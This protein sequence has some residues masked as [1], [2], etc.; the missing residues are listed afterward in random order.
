MTTIGRPKVGITVLG[1]TG[2]EPNDGS[3]AEI[4]G[5]AAG[6]ILSTLDPITMDTIAG[7]PG[8][9][10]AIAAYPGPNLAAIA[11]DTATKIIWAGDTGNGNLYKYFP[12]LN[13]WDDQQSYPGT[14]AISVAVNSITNDVWIADSPSGGQGVVYKL[15]GGAGAFVAH[16]TLPVNAS[17]GDLDVNETTGDVW[18]THINASPSTDG[19]L[20]LEGGAQLGTFLPVGSWPGASPAGLE[21]NSA[22]GDVWTSSLTTPTL[23]K[24]TGGTGS[25]VATGTGYAG[26]VMNSV[27][28]DSVNGHIWVTDSGVGTVYKLP[29]GAD[30]PFETIGSLPSGSPTDVSIDPTTY[31]AWVSSTSTVFQYYDAPPFVQPTVSAHNNIGLYLQTGTYPEAALARMGMHSGAN[32]L[33]IL[34]GGTSDFHKFNTNTVT[35]DSVVTFPDTLPQGLSVDSLNGDLWTVSQ[36]SKKI[37][38]NLG[39]TQGAFTEESTFVAGATTPRAIAINQATKDL[40]ILANDLNIFKRDAG[41]TVWNQVG[42]YAASATGFG[43]MDI[44]ST[45]GRLWII[46]EAQDKVFYLDDGTTTYIEAPI[47]DTPTSVLR[48]LAVDHSNGNVFITDAITDV[49]YRLNGPGGRFNQVGFTPN[50]NI[51]SVAVDSTDGSLY[52][53]D[54]VGNAVYKSRGRFGVTVGDIVQST[55]IT[56]IGT[57]TVGAIVS[58]GFGDG[59]SGSYGTLDPG[60]Q[61]TPFLKELAIRYDTGA[62]ADSEII[63]TLDIGVDLP[64]NT[65]V[66]MQFQGID[67]LFDQLQS[68]T[69]I[70]NG[71]HTWVFK[72]SPSTFGI[73]DW[74]VGQARDTL[75]TQE[76]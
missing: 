59:D 24:L 46:D 72:A 6:I 32:A 45:T 55:E 5:D 56:V 28:V 19:I 13:F 29:D 36:D 75:L 39:G 8:F 15:A 44:D 47:A 57:K 51:G 64:Q 18:L 37:Y 62:P 66:Q 16:G 30:G 69:P 9:T 50:N 48:G 53:G 67:T 1:E 26:T 52:I 20:K 14:R 63:I 76:I 33:W 4:S 73:G 2:L 70:T 42:N 21:I 60:A 27:A 61:L 10:D 25:Y 34:D 12:D 40:W 17:I 54:T 58:L 7:M 49:I 23:Y 11:I 71:P 22:T 38:V 68:F 31:N 74:V 43:E 41:D 3:D 65:V 35:Y